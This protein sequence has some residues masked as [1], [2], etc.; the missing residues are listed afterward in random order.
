[1]DGF[2]VT[3]GFT[4]GSSGVEVTSNGNTLANNTAFNN[5]YGIFLWRSSNNRLINNIVY[6][7]DKGISISGTNNMLISNIVM[8]NQQAGVELG[9]SLGYNILTNN[10]VS[11]NKVGIHIWTSTK[12][13]ITNNTISSNSWYG[14]WFFK[15]S[16][17]TIYHNNFENNTNQAY[18]GDLPYDSETG[19]TWDKG[20]P[21]GG[22][23][24]SDHVCEGN[25]SAVS[26]IISPVFLVL[27]I[28][29][30]LRINGGGCKNDGT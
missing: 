24:W 26:H 3:G 7:N 11:N 16:E 1:V 2:K 30:H 20:L 14:I 8:N 22:N 23:Y 13:T 21:V 5:M 28:V 27:K 9:P 25:P 17:N 12:N 4:G 29:I 19:N 6:S 18:E 10:T 15:A